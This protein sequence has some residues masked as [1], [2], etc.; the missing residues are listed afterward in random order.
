MIQRWTTHLHTPTGT[1]ERLHT[2]QTQPSEVT[3]RHSLPHAPR[4][5]NDLLVPVLFAA[6]GFLLEVEPQQ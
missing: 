1:Q 4:S 6:E 5:S 2:R 3:A